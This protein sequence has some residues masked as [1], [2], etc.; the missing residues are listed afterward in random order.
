MESSANNRP[1]SSPVNSHNEWDPLEEVIV[2]TLE[3]AV[4]PAWEPGFSGFVPAEIRSQL[5]ENKNKLVLNNGIT[6]YSGTPIP[7]LLRFAAQSELDN[8]AAVLEREGVKVQRPTPID[9]SKSITTHRW[10]ISNQINCSQPRDVLLVVGDLIIETPMG[11]R[12]RYFEHCCYKDLCKEYFRQGCRWISAPRPELADDIYVMDHCPGEDNDEP[13]YA[14]RNHEPLFD[15]ASI[16]RCGKDL[17]VI[18]DSCCNSMGIEWLQRHLEGYRIH[19]VKIVEARTLHID[20]T[21]VP[22]APGKVMINLKRVPKIPEIFRTWDILEA[23]EPCSPPDHP[24]LMSSNNLHMNI[25]M[26]DEKR[27]V[28]SEHE[29][30]M[31]A[32]LKKWGFKPIPVPFLYHYTMGG[33]IH[34]AT[35]DIRRKGELQSYF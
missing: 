5:K 10:S 18:K 22:M 1:S 24:F 20:T 21:I 31:I 6:L 4:I 17:F 25:L 11:L 27:V 29:E 23:P 8:L 32:S 35:L 28:V 33:G 15:A 16:T 9:F 34:C 30:A 19:E 2:G 7:E 13:R 12:A 3:G 26:L 14:I